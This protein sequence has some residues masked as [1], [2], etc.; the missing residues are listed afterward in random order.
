M[1]EAYASQG[2][3]A[4]ENS[5]WTQK[6]LSARTWALLANSG[7]VIKCLLTTEGQKSADAT[8]VADIR[9][10]EGSDSCPSLPFDLRENISF[11][12]LLQH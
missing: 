11:S 6:A 10:K 8:A 4:Q 1:E 7:K 9:K 5:G 3:K 12:L 2:G